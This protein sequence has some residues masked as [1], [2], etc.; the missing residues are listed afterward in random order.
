MLPL[1]YKL[2]IYFIAFSAIMLIFLW[3]FQTMFLESCYTLIKQHQVKTY[4]SQIIKSI[5][6]GENTTETI[7]YATHNQFH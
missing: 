5:Q 3:V 7:N 2:G 6:S 4:A 1:R